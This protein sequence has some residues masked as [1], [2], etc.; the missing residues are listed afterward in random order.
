MKNESMTQSNSEHLIKTVE[1][2]VEKCQM[3][4]I[5]EKEKA[6]VLLF[7]FTE[8]Q[9]LKTHTAP[10]EVLLGVFEGEATF[11]IRDTTSLIQVGDIIR[12]PANEPHS[13]RANGN[14]KMLLIK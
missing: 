3:Q 12:I 5:M 6:K 10:V 14:F 8:G 7:T 9:E 13:L 4:V 11:T 2:S 1:Y